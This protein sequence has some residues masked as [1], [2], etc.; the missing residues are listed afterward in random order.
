MISAAAMILL[1]T[2]N[3]IPS[4][5]PGGPAQA[6]AAREHHIRGLGALVREWIRIGASGSQTFNTL[7]DR[8]S[9]SDVIVYVAIVDR[10]PG[11]GSGQLSFITATKTVRY[12]RIELVRGGNTVELVSVLG[13]ELQHA[14]EIADAPGVRDSRAMAV[15]YL[16]RSGIHA[17]GTRYDSVEAR[18]TG[19]RVRDELAS[20]PW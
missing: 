1:A 6:I 14:V 5:P 16:L 19:Q 3:G 20:S 15:F 7:L 10:I 18:I 4:T 9:T 11:G 13:H 17:Q 8:L 2:L 12:L